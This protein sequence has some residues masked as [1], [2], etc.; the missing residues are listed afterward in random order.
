M[1]KLDLTPRMKAQIVF[2]SAVIIFIIGFLMFINGLNRHSI[3]AIRKESGR[4][5]FQ[6]HDHYLYMFTH[7]T[8]SYAPVTDVKYFKSDSKDTPSNPLLVFF[9]TTDDFKFYAEKNNISEEDLKELDKEIQ[10]FMDDEELTE[11]GDSFFYLKFYGILGL[12]MAG[13]IGY[14]IIPLFKRIPKQTEEEKKEFKAKILGKIRDL[15]KIKNVAVKKMKD[16]KTKKESKGK[17]LKMT[18]EVISGDRLLKILIP[19]YDRN[20]IFKPEIFETPYTHSIAL[21]CNS[22]QKLELQEKYN[23][24]YEYII[25]D[26]DASTT[27]MVMKAE[28]WVKDFTGYLMVQTENIPDLTSSIA[29][30]F[31]KEHKY[32]QNECTILVTESNESNIPTGKIMKNMAN[33]IVSI[34]EVAENNDTSIQ[35]GEIYLGL[36]CFNSKKIFNNLNELGHSSSLEGIPL[37]RIIEKY[38]KNRS[39]LNTFVVKNA[40]KQDV[41]PKSSAQVIAT[42]TKKIAALI[43]STLEFDEIKIKNNYEALS[44]EIDKIYTIINPGNKGKVEELLENKVELVFSEGKSGDGD[45]ALKTNDLLRNFTG[46][47]V[48]I[49]EGSITITKDMINKIISEHTNQNNICTYATNEGNN[50]LYCVDSFQF[51]YAVKKISRDPETKKYMLSGMVDILVEA[52][53]RVQEISL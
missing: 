2:F 13:L 5:E 8:I 1:T 46:L 41:K 31:Y 11:F 17:G 36:F 51:L 49:P 48:V 19:V 20:I 52:K 43:I 39:K 6:F 23:N 53:K 26:K 4:V 21:A 16:V 40:I 50:I 37:T 15:K 45:D 44:P 38:H 24:D 22:S 30:D 18:K 33:R 14:F 25:C 47:I 27:E 28:S 35:V 3:S 7:N 9:T 34:S 10:V 12:F 42:P 32:Q 29:S